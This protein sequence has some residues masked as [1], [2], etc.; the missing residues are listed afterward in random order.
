M[1]FRVMSPRS[2]D[3]FGG[4]T[5]P[6]LRVKAG[7]IGPPNFSSCA[8]TNDS[9]PSISIVPSTS[10]TLTRASLIPPSLPIEAHSTPAGAGRLHGFH[11][12]RMRNSLTVALFVACAATVLAQNPPT[13]P[14]HHITTSPHHHITTSVMVIRGSLVT[15]ADRLSDRSAR[16]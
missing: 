11:N 10:D 15:S 16:R 3:G 9:V 8:L 6:F 14:H 5:T 12:P 2:P 1:P 13:S 7:R 4:S